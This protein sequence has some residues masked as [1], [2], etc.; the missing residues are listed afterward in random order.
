MARATGLLAAVLLLLGG[1]TWV[2]LE[3]GGV[4]VVETHGSHGDVRST[5][6]W[7]VE[8]EGEL[9]LEAGTRDNGWFVDLLVDPDL[10]FRWPAGS[11]H[12]RAHPVE[13]PVVQQRIR[14]LMR[15]KYGWRD[16]WVGL[17][18]VDHHESVPVR[19][20]GLPG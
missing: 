20:E 17:L 13:N 16:D 18:L 5:H 8:H 9:W 2:A 11:G 1:I 3:S 14:D 6:V 19:L 15:A 12:Y 4:G 7:Y 10:D